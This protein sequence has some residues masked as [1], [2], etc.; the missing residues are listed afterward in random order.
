MNS[1]RVSCKHIVNALIMAAL[2]AG[3]ALAKPLPREFMQLDPSQGWELSG[4]TEYGY[5]NWRKG[6]MSLTLRPM[7]TTPS[8]SLRTPD[9]WYRK[10]RLSAVCE[11]QPPTREV[12]ELQS[13][14]Q[15]RIQREGEEYFDEREILGPIFDRA[16]EQWLNRP[17][18][19]AEL[20]GVFLTAGFDV[21]QV[22]PQSVGSNEVLVNDRSTLKPT[23]YFRPGGTVCMLELEGAGAEGPEVF[24][25][26]L[27]GMTYELSPDKPMTSSPVAKASATS[28]PHTPGAAPAVL[29][30]A[31]IGGLVAF[32]IRRQNQFQAAASNASMVAGAE[33]VT[34]F[35]LL[36]QMGNRGNQSLDAGMPARAQREYLKVLWYLASKGMLDEYLLGKAYLGLMMAEAKNPQGNLGSL[37]DVPPAGLPGPMEVVSTLSGRAQHVFREK[38]LSANDSEIYKA[39]CAFHRKKGPLPE[40]S[41]SPWDLSLVS[42]ESFPVMHVPTHQIATVLNPASPPVLNPELKGQEIHISVPGLDEG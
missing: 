18:L 36:C 41:M 42:S 27:K 8:R 30:V 26:L 21:H 40:G 3:T 39:L 10:Q 9:T 7:E 35:P 11:F 19:Q 16:L 32:S 14:I 17:D 34:A 1:S 24:D 29:I 38:M 28:G 25:K 20:L 31:L 4:D 22:R 15:S 13:R 5:S 12:L 37:I 23:A 33:H 6:D 2:L